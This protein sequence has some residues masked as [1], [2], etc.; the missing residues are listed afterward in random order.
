MTL[1]PRALYKQLLA[2]SFDDGTPEL[3]F[4]SRLAR[5]NGWSPAYSRRVIREYRRFLFLAVT[6][7]H[8]VTPSEQVDQAWHLHLTFSRS[9]WDRLCRDLLGRPL[10][11]EPTRGGPEEAVK[12]RAQYL[13]T[14]DAYRSAFAEEPPADIWPAVEIRFGEDLHLVRV[15]T[16]RYLVLS[17]T[18]LWC[19]A[20]LWAAGLWVIALVAAWSR[21]PMNPFALHG[22]AF[23][24]VLIPALV[25][26][27]VVGVVIRARLRSPGPQPGDRT[28]E[29]EWAEVA[30][31]VGGSRR[32]TEAALARLVA[33]GAVRVSPDGATLEPTGQTTEE[34][35]S[36]EVALLSGLPVQRGDQKAREELAVRA[37]RAFTR[38]ANALR[39]EGYVMDDDRARRIRWAAVLPVV[40][41]LLFLAAPRL[42]AGVLSGRPVG[43]L[44]VTVLAGS[45]FGLAVGLAGVDHL[46]RRGRHILRKVR[47]AKRHLQRG[48]QSHRPDTIG[49]AVALFGVAVLASGWLD[50]LAPWSAPQPS[51][52][53]TGG[54][55]GGCGGCGGGCGGCGGCGG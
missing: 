24:G 33:A 41:V 46:T 36:V 42:I 53:G 20:V 25:A 45:G 7:G 17:K 22:S 6:A 13:Q 18:A 11:H 5:E 34:L 50:M 39:D 55:G 43:F 23:L 32:L 29:L 16:A 40:A 27:T 12:F 10:H 28:S 2:F 51:S 26:A 9:Y 37:S 15:N 4:E 3:P 31:L 38:Q 48:V 35:S 49:M 19:W 21:G 1:T 47:T 54:C 30:H 8:P 52:S 44:L 14:L